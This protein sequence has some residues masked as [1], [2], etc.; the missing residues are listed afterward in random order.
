[1]TVTVKEQQRGVILTVLTEE[2]IWL[3]IVHDNAKPNQTKQMVFMS[4]R[5]FHSNHFFVCLST[6]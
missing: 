6:I 5:I 2:K 1:M 4:F 3:P